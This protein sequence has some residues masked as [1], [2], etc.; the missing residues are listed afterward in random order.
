M[1]KI[2]ALCQESRL[3]DSQT[4]YALALARRAKGK[5]VRV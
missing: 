5:E 2:M 4:A 1:K 3:T